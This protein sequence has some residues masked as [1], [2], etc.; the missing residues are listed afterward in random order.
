MISFVSDDM[1]EDIIETSISKEDPPR[2]NDF[3]FHTFQFI[4]ARPTA[5]NTAI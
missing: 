4:P 5:T 3:P 2:S 1:S